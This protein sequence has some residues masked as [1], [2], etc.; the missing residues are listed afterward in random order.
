VSF[1]IFLPYL[2]NINMISDVLTKKERDL[3]INHLSNNKQYTTFDIATF[4]HALCYTFPTWRAEQLCN[5][6]IAYDYF[7]LYIT[8]PEYF[9]IS[10]ADNPNGIYGSLREL[11]DCEL[12]ISYEQFCSENDYDTETGHRL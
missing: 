9:T 3:L 2:I 12:E 10:H 1:S 4:H 7:V 8:H 6:D 5:S 11:V